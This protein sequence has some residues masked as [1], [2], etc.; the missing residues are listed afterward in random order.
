MPYLSSSNTYAYL[1]VTP[2]LNLKQNIYTFSNL[3]LNCDVKST[4]LNIKMPEL[5]EVVVAQ[6]VER[7][8]P[9]PEIFGSNPHIIKCYLLLTVLKM[10]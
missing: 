3:Y 5:W 1:L 2:D 8:L 10:Y 9:T 6:L 7:L 4:K